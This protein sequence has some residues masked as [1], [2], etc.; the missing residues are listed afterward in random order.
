MPNTEKVLVEKE[1]EYF[2]PRKTLRRRYGQTQKAGVVLKE[3]AKYMFKNGQLE[4]VEEAPPAPELPPIQMVPGETYK[5]R[6]GRKIRVF[7]I[8]K[9]SPDF[10]VVGMIETQGVWRPLV[11]NEEGVTK[12]PYGAGNDIHVLWSEG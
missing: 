11:W 7:A 1:E 5:S 8:N 6:D 9:N 2:K 4:L 3:G 12:R 10:P